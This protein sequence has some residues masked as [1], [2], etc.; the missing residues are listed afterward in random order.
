MSRTDLNNSAWST[1]QWLHDCAEGLEKKLGRKIDEERRRNP[2]SHVKITDGAGKPWMIDLDEGYLEQL[3]AQMYHYQKE[4]L[5]HAN[6][7]SRNKP[8]RRSPPGFT[9]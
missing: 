7:P 9:P 5:R 8:T 3:I 1:A 2:F 4:L 6:H